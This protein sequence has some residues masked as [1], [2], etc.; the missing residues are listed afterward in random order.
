MKS[1]WIGV[2]VATLMGCLVGCHVGGNGADD[3]RSLEWSETV[4]GLR[5]GTWRSQLT[6]ESLV[7]NGY[8]S[9]A[10]ENTLT[11]TNGY[12]SIRPTYP[13][14]EL[15]EIDSTTGMSI[16]R[17]SGLQGG[18]ID[19]VGPITSASVCAMPP[20][21][22]LVARV[23]L[24]EGGVQKI[25]SSKALSVQLRLRIGAGD[26]SSAMQKEHLMRSEQLWTGQLASQVVQL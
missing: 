5:I 26:W 1:S 25:R 13:N 10:I 3:L 2:L 23:W 15:V 9:V 7:S 21:A 19:R 16:T 22:I 24:S 4:G 20:G 12:R 17:M 18:G 8:I 14:L 11:S 6:K